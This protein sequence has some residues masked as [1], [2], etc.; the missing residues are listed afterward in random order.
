MD[1][2]WVVDPKKQSMNKINKKKQKSENKRDSEPDATG[3]SKE[4]EE[5]IAK[6]PSPL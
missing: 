2:G 6:A 5:S 1:S 3:L 4:A